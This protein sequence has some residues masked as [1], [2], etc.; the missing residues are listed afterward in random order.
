MMSSRDADIAHAAACLHGG[1][2]ILHAT[3]AVWGLACSAVDPAAI[4]AVY[5]LKQRPPE[6]GVIVVAD[7]W[8]RVQPWLA[9][10]APEVLARAQATWPGPHT[11]VFPTA[12]DCPPWLAGDR[13]SLAVRITAHTQVRALCAAFGGAL[14]STSA[15]RAGQPP[16]RS[17]DEVDPAIRSAVDCILPGETDGLGQPTTIR[18]ARSGETFRA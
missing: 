8:Q 18:D 17:L 3:E 10:V 15:N 1:G 13:A 6:K 11:W 4:A 7:T 5:A 14:I 2:I 9:Q 12:P 16:V